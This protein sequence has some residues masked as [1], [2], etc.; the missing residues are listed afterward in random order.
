[1]LFV[2]VASNRY[3]SNELVTF[4]FAQELL[5]TSVLFAVP[6]IQMK[7]PRGPLDSKLSMPVL[8]IKMASSVFV[9]T[10]AEPLFAL[11][12]FQQI[13]SPLIRLPPPFEIPPEVPAAVTPLFR[14]V[15]PQMLSAV[16]APLPMY[17]AARLVAVAP[18]LSI[19][20]LSLIWQPEMTSLPLA[21]KIMPGPATVRRTV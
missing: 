17:I 18:S 4:A 21:P 16:C 7:L 19:R 13:D 2:V 15:L 10:M 8:P 14:N 12:V 11:K 3:C 9:S 1:M 5:L 6:R 20:W